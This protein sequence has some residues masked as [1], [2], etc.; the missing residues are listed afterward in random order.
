MVKENVFK[1]TEIGLIPED[2]EVKPLEEYFSYI[3]YGFT[4][5]MPT[6]NEGVWM[7]TAN[8]VKKGKINYDSARKTSIEAFN[9]LL[10]NKSRPN[11]G[12]LLLTKD[13]S[14]G[15]VAIVE[16]E[17]IC[18]NQSVAVIRPNDKICVKYLKHLLQD[19]YY[20][21]TMLENAGGST[22]KH[23]YITVVNKMSIGVP[24][25]PEQQAIAEALSDADAWIE[26]LE[27]L[28][29][30]KRLLKQG[31]M[32]E[33]LTPKEDWEVKFI[34][35]IAKV[36]RGASPRPIDSPIW[37][38]EKSNIGWVR[39]SDVTS[40]NKY[41]ETTIQRLSDLGV[42]QSRYVSKKSLVMSICATIGKPIITKIEVCI[43]DGFVVFTDLVIDQD[44]LY[45]YLKF[46]EK[47]WSKNGQTGS[48]MNLNTTLINTTEIVFPKSKEEQTRIA[49]ILSDMDAEIEALEAQLAK[50][51]QIKQGMMQ[52]LL[53]G[54]VRLV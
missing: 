20:Q 29:A 54:R 50:A 18:I 34:K 44:Y 17:V 49:T 28:I 35:E 39:I 53:T 8:D 13:G 38:D 24:P 6:T 1:Q 10:T 47:Q 27:Q 9:K 51:Q 22:I 30:K 26:S 36:T 12:D 21:K 14:L 40:S 7:I 2:W 52:E 31:A 33:L 48:Q 16:K 4:N 19:N 15:R 46:I 32:Q 3:S 11:E 45:N 42:K 41:L 5:P 43:H 25:L 37:F 23:I